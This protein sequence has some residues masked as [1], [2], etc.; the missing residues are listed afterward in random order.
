MFLIANGVLIS[1]IGLARSVGFARNF[2]A[3]PCAKVLG[4]CIM[5]CE[6]YFYAAWNVSPALFPISFLDP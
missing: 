3:P 2:S 1:D 5:A 6:R 4:D